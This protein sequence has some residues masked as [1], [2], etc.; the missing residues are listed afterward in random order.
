MKK[1]DPF[2]NR[3][4]AIKLILRRDIVE[5][6]RRLLYVVVLLALGLIAVP[7][8]L[9]RPKDQRVVHQDLE[10][11][12]FFDVYP[13]ALAM[14]QEWQLDAVLDWAMFYVTPSGSDPAPSAKSEFRSPT[15][16]NETLTV[17]AVQ[18]GNATH[19]ERELEAEQ[20]STAAP[21]SPID[22]DLV[23]IDS[24]DALRVVQTVGADE[25][26]THYA[27]QLTWPQLL[28]LGDYTILGD[29]VEV[30]WWGSVVLPEAGAVLDVVVDAHSGK[31]VEIRGGAP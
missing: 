17:H 7:I 5:G 30:A 3:T 2:R 9:A 15:V 12:S 14:A 29:E 4:E 1:P 20:G 16:A 28:S 23:R 21:M 8:V 13:N 31:V 19:L 18:V 22:F 26:M 24:V 11:V 10:V 6:E 25:L 27:D